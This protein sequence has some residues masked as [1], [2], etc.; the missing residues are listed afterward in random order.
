MQAVKASS[1]AE[2]SSAVP[3]A[4]LQDINRI[5]QTTEEEAKKTK[6]IIFLWPSSSLKKTISLEPVLQ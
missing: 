3:D 1:T 5:D 4:K 6:L 2:V